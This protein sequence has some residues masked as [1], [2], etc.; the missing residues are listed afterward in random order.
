[1]KPF[2]IVV[3]IVLL[4]VIGAQFVPRAP[5]NRAAATAGSFAERFHPPAAVL[6]VLT[7]ACFDC[8][9]NNTRYPWYARL[10][11]VN[12]FLARHIK[13]GKK[14]LN[15]DEVAQYGLRKQRTQFNGII[16][17][18]S[19]GTMPLPSYRMIHGTLNAGEKQVLIRYFTDLKDRIGKKT[20]ISQPAG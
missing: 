13:K 20:G 6:Q 5:E 14:K 19:D 16:N 3:G 11:P 18:L 15:F 1:M 4:L 2:R 10:Q 7:A 9:S 8:H 12:A 17:A